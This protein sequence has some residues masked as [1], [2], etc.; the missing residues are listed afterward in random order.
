MHDELRQLHQ[1]V[2]SPS[3]AGLQ[4]HGTADNP[5]TPPPRST[6]SIRWVIGTLAAV[7]A[8]APL[9]DVIV[10][11]V[12]VA[13]W[14][15]G[16]QRQCATVIAKPSSPVYLEI[17]Q[18]SLKQKRY[19]EQIELYPALDPVDT[20]QGAYRAVLVRSEGTYGWMLDSQLTPA[21]CNP[22]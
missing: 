5:D 12:G 19:G 14:L 4:K 22:R 15:R 16:P 3:L 6:P 21:S 1:Q 2:G 11:V 18:P 8:V 9:T 13:G 20:P 10:N 7:A 17:G